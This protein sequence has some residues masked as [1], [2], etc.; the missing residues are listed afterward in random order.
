MSAGK[1]E[2]VGNRYDLRARIAG[3]GMGEV[4]RAHDE[5]LDRPVA[6]KMLHAGLSDDPGFL[7][8]F[9][10]EA[11]N[12]ARLSHGNV[13][14]V[15]DYGEDEGTA[16][17]VMEFVDGDPLSS[18]IRSRAPMTAAESIELLVQAAQALEAAHR[19]GVIHRDV[20]PANI[21]VTG[22]GVA[23]LT[24]F[25]I[26]RALG[27]AG[28][29]RAG[30]VLGTPQ[31]LP[32]EAA[33]GTEIGPPS[34][35]YSLAIVAFEMLTGDWPFHADT[36]VGLAMAHIQQE[37][38]ALPGGVPEL[39][40]EVVRR[41][42]A[43]D[44]EARYESA[45]AF[46]QAL[47]EAL[48]QSPADEV[49]TDIS[50]ASTTV[51]DRAEV[52]D[53]LAPSS[54]AAV[55]DELSAPTT[56][57]PSVGDEPVRLRVGQNSTIVGSTVE[58]LVDIDNPLGEPF[59]PMAFEVGADGLALAESSFVFFNNPESASGAVAL[60]DNGIRIN[61]DD[62]PDDCASVNVAVAD[63][64]PLGDQQLKVRVLVG[65]VQLDLD[66]GALT[67]ERAAILLRVYRRDGLWKVRN[68]MAGWA[69][70]IEPMVRDF[71][72]DVAG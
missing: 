3:G 9:R 6:V 60:V 46:A 28:V 18:I 71:G 48:T 51:F 56:V 4:W 17:L 62:L 1:T 36:A 16:Y 53:S 15:H 25:G 45:A 35:V 41:G 11:R 30:E 32:P 69:D 68:V 24:D 14:Q 20:K 31:Y 65:G 33:L 66:S 50:A 29:T 47:R 59:D 55:E 37:P 13:A 38:P 42:M 72:I 5:V 26:A 44:P 52:N 67:A 10:S 39:V 2:R 43:K 58:V 63:D 12:A 40:A 34:D 57:N 8:R 23:K 54:T 49:S 70:G 7:E 19:K 27:T 64:H 22:D 21:V 61:L